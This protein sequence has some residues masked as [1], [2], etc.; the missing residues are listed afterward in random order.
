MLYNTARQ[1]VV[2]RHRW[3]SALAATRVSC[4]PPCRVSCCDVSKRQGNGSLCFFTRGITP[5]SSVW[6]WLL[7]PSLAS[8][9]S[10]P[11]PLSSSQLPS[12]AQITR[13]EGQGRC[14]WASCQIVRDEHRGLQLYQHSSHTAMHSSFMSATLVSMTCTGRR[15]VSL[16]SVPERAPQ[17]Y[18][19]GE[20]RSHRGA[21]SRRPPPSRRSSY[22]PAWRPRNL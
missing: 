5:W 1:H 4:C 10:A 2:V 16:Q 11:H 15:Y 18:V 7:L 13:L 6:P 3:K 9:P 17:W 14:H 12:V 20:A 21:P 19:P 22:S 8:H